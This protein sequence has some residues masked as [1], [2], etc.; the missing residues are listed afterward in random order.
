M[1]DPERQDSI[2]QRQ[3]TSSVSNSASSHPLSAKNVGNVLVTCG[4]RQVRSGPR[5]CRRCG[6]KQARDDCLEY[7]LLSSMALE[8]KHPLPCARSCSRATSRR[9]TCHRSSCCRC[10]FTI[11]PWGRSCLVRGVRVPLRCGAKHARRGAG[12]H[13]RGP[14]PR[15]NTQPREVVARSLRA[16]PDERIN[17]RLWERATTTTM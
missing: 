12:I 7:Q 16:R 1:S 5:V 17:S 14:A 9:R 4:V 3:R 11:G 10:S 2:V 8:N 15:C 13:A 6:N